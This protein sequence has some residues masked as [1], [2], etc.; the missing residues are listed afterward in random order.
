MKEKGMEREK[1]K[2]KGKG[3]E[4]LF[5]VCFVGHLAETGIFSQFHLQ[6]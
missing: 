3:G 4:V 5:Q 2:G 6:F 1:S